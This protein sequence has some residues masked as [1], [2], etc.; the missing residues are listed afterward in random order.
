M[1]FLEERIMKD[2]VVK[3]GN[4]LKVD[5]FLNHQMDI[6]LFNELL[7]F[8]NEKSNIQLAQNENS[9]YNLVYNSIPFAFAASTSS[10]VDISASYERFECTCKS[11]FIRFTSLYCQFSLR[12]FS[13]TE[14]K[15]ANLKLIELRLI[16]T[17]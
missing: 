2:G 5:C 4:V 6:E 1:N 17:G 8:E 14:E 3:P 16:L 13:D 7:M 9:Q 10:D 11:N 12:H 15:S